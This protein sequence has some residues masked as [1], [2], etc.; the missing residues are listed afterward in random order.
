MID[1][2]NRKFGTS[3]A[4]YEGDDYVAVADGSGSQTATWSFAIAT[5]GSYA[6]SAKWVAKMTVSPF[7]SG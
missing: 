1:R 5:A 3:P 6:V 4:G 7:W 2:R